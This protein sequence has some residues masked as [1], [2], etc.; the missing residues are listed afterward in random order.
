MVLELEGHSVETADS[1]SGALRRLA[2]SKPD[3]AIIDIGLADMD[4]FDIAGGV[5]RDESCKGVY[6]IALSGYADEAYRNRAIAAGFNAYLTKP[7]SM[8]QLGAILAGCNSVG[9][10]SAAD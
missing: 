5:K 9:T 4:G 8:S 10:Q 3:I 6:L 1:G 7:L 2:S